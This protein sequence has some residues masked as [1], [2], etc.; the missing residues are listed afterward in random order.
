MIEETAL[1]DSAIDLGE[2]SECAVKRPNPAGWET[3]HNRTMKKE[4]LITKAK[5]HPPRGGVG[6][7][8]SRIQSTATQVNTIR[9]VQRT[10]L[11]ARGEVEP[12]EAVLQ[13]SWKVT[14]SNSW[15]IVTVVGVIGGS[16]LE[17]GKAREDGRSV[18]IGRARLA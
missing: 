18:R 8:V 14:R 9:R 6:S 5:L 4:E 2:I 12:N 7:I 3:Q 10:S 17:R 15:G 11:L 1:V 16:R 13:S